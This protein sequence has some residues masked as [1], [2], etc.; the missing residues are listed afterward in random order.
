MLLVSPGGQ[1]AIVMSD[2]G[3]STDVVACNLT[4]DDEAPTQLPDFDAISC[5]GSYQPADYEAGDPFP[6][7]APTPSGNVAL[8][9]F[10]GGPANGTWSLYIVDDAGSRRR[11]HRELVAGHRQRWAASATSATTASAATTTSA[12]ATASAASTTASAASTAA[13]ATASASATSTASAATAATSASAT[14]ASATSASA[15]SASA[16]ASSAGPLPRSTRARAAARSCEAEDPGE[17]LL[18]RQCPARSLEAL[19]AGTRRQAVAA[20]RLAPAPWLPGQPGGRPAAKHLNQQTNGGARSS[21][22]PHFISAA[23]VR[24]S[25]RGREE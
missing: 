23:P 2:A 24:R 20:A 12:S 6:A 11:Q 14:S 8:S 5:P 22:R 3:G 19:P 18:G 13:S 16:S 15:T 17:A 4:L 7:P 9:T 10:D 25:R 1:N 21:G